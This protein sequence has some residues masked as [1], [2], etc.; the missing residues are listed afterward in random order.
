MEAY[1]TTHFTSA[2]RE[3][4]SVGRHAGESCCQ[5]PT[6]AGKMS[7]MLGGTLW[8]HRPGRRTKSMRSTLAYSIRIPSTFFV[9]S[10]Y[11]QIRATACLRARTSH[12]PKPRTL[13]PKYK[14]CSHVCNGVFAQKKVLL[15][16]LVLLAAAQTQGKD[17]DPDQPYI[18]IIWP[19]EGHNFVGEEIRYSVVK[20]YALNKSAA[21]AAA[22]SAEIR[23]EF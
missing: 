9:Y 4:R 1:Q 2:V 21:H 18:E 22:M 10:L 11:S 16:L 12:V 19:P 3:K 15:W 5:L 14:P 6:D 20:V 23:Q 17:P 13:N 8:A 7:I